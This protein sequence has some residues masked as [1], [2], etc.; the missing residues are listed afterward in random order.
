MIPEGTFSVAEMQPSTPLVNYSETT[1]SNPINKHTIQT[2]GL[3][4]H[5]TQRERSATTSIPLTS[6]EFAYFPLCS[7]F[8]VSPLFK[9]HK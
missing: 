4:L 5:V 2:K 8:F 1:M 9:F 6:N 7:S 3:T